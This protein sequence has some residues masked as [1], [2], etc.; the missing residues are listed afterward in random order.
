MPPYLPSAFLVMEDRRFYRHGG[1]D[2]WGLAR[3]A[4]ADLKAGR[5]VQG[6]ST[7]TQQLV[8]VLFLTPDR[9]IGRKIVE[10][11]GAVQLE[12]LLTKEQILELY[13]NRIYLGAGAYG[14]DGAARAYFGKSAREVTLAEAAMLATLTNA[15]SLNSPRRNLNAAQRRSA[16]VLRALVDHGGMRGSEIAQALATPATIV[17]EGRNLERGYFLDTAADEASSLVP[18]AAGDLTIV[19]TLD[20]SMQAAASTAIEDVLKKR[21]EGAQAQQAALVAMHPDG[22]VR[23]ITGGRNYSQS[24]FNRA[25]NAHRSPG[26][27]FKPLVYLTALEQ[28][29]SRD[30]IRYDEP[31]SVQDYTPANFDGSY[32]GPVT[33]QDALVRSINTVAVGLGQEVGL[34]SVI[35]TAQRLGIKSALQPNASLALGTSEVTPLELTAAYASF[36]SLGLEAVPYTVTEIRAFDGSVLYKRQPAEP[37]RVISNENTLAMNAMLYEAVQSGTGR[38]AALRGRQVAGKTGTSADH[39]D[40]WFIGY[41]TDL[42]AGV[43]VGNDDFAP[44]KRVTGGAIPAQIWRGFMEAAH[45]NIPAKP[46]PKADPIHAP[47]I[48]DYDYRSGDGFLDRLGRFFDRLFRVPRAQARPEQTAPQMQRPEQRLNG[49]RYSLQPRAEALT[50]QDDERYAYQGYPS[51]DAMRLPQTRF[52]NERDYATERRREAMQ[53]PRQERFR[54]PS[55]YARDRYAYG[56]DYGYPRDRQRFAYGYDSRERAGYGY[57][58]YGYYAEQRR[59][60]DRYSER[61]YGGF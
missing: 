48:A 40:A 2:P 19:T 55:E 27:G 43:W 20:A 14:V 38:G 15:P 24:T 10:M 29:L 31:I 26:S 12:R 9:T 21:G 45:K 59:N 42:V 4:L 33:L 35:S 61:R 25:T 5:F 44:M 37:R 32:A 49:E 54:E 3:A 53:P 30:T 52:R 41:S 58:P 17:S 7:I 13:L 23:A 47:L 57:R 56:P 1:I 36:A 50:P 6:G 16:R 18:G 22:A 39:R 8:K 11:A 34:T 28:G 51:A 60:R 46:L